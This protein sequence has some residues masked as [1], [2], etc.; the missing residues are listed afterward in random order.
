MRQNFVVSYTVYLSLA[1]YLH[2]SNRWGN[3]WEVSG[4]SHFSTGFPVTLTNYS[5]TSLWGTQSNGVNNL[6][7]DEPSVQSRPLALNHNPRNGQL[8]FNTELFSVP[9]VGDPGNARRRFF[10]GPGM[11]NYDMSL[12]KNLNLSESHTLELRA[13]TFNVFNHAQ[14]CGPQTVNGNITDRNNM[15]K[16]GFGQVVSAAAPRLIQLAAKFVF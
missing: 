7:L 14:F 4:I 13:E 9:A 3:G 6:P 12:Q 2:A 5:D 10:S 8:Y 11:D 16:Y 15:N 1:H